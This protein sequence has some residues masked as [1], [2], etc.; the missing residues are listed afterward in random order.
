M[1][2][3]EATVLKASSFPSFLPDVQTFETLERYQEPLRIIMSEVDLTP[4]PVG[5]RSTGVVLYL[6]CCSAVKILL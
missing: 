5:V 2:P 4:I 6:V 3:R 1:T